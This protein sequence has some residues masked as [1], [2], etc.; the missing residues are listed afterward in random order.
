MQFFSFH[1]ERSGLRLQL[2]HG[3][4]S[5]AEKMFRFASFFPACP[6]AFQKIL[7][8]HGIICFDIVRSYAR[9]RSDKLGDDSVRHGALRN[10]FRKIDDCFAEP[11]RSFFKIVNLFPIGF[12]ANDRHRAV[13]PKRIVFFARRL[14]F[15]FRHSFVLRHSCLVISFM[16]QRKR[17]QSRW[18]WSPASRATLARPNRSSPVPRPPRRL[19]HG[20]RRCTRW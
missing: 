13:T 3:T 14:P 10:C 19:R 7:L 20:V 11:R 9:P 4:N 5:H 2:R 17:S 15:S 16:R 1:P 6:N 8:R 18:R 12:F